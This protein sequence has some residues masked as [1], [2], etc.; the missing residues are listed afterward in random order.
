MLSVYRGVED[1]T[2]PGCFASVT[3]VHVLTPPLI[4]EP[5]GGRRVMV[6]S[7]VLGGRSL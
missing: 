2:C 1:E 6:S 3:S 7:V 4:H 5:G